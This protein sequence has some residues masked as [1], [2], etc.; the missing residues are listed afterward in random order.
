MS[1]IRKTKSGVTY[2]HRSKD[3]RLLEANRHLYDKILEWQGGGC[4][5]CGK[6]PSPKR[7]LDLD[8]DHQRMVIRG[9]LCWSCNKAVPDGKDKDWILRCA[10]YIGRTITEDSLTYGPI[11]GTN[12]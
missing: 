9:L 1:R 5:L 7:K 11:R 2:G 12:E 4:A 8:H 3:L 6:A 10:E